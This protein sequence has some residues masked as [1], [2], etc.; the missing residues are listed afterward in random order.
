ML[1]N[2]TGSRKVLSTPVKGVYGKCNEKQV[3]R[4]TNEG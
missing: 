3:L 2:R 1:K 4:V